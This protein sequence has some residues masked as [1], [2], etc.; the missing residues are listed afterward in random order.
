MSMV[1]A[2]VFALPL[3]LSVAAFA[4][5]PAQPQQGA[6]IAPLAVRWVKFTDPV[7]HA[8]TID[9]P[10]GWRVSGGI[11]RMSAVAVRDSGTFVNR[12][13]NTTFYNVDTTQPYHFID[14]WGAIHNSGSATDP[15]ESNWHPLQQVPPGQ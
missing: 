4:Q 5:Q 2:A 13:T 11:K 15:A 7:E 8:F 10:A 3:F 9:V 1:K 14:N 6:T 12:G